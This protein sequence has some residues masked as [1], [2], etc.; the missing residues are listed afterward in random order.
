MEG[1]LGIARLLG[2]GAWTRALKLALAI[3]LAASATA[4]QAEEVTIAALGDSLTQGYG[5]PQGEG[6]VPQLEAW[7]AAQGADVEVL[8]AGV[9]GDTTAGG[10]SRVA[11]TLTP[12]VDAIIVALGGNDLLRGIDPA[13]SRANLEGI[14]TAARKAGVEVLLVGLDAPGN[15]GPDYKAAFDSMY[16]DLAEDYDA[17]YFES[18]LKGLSDLPDRGQAMRD[19][20]QEDGIHPSAKGVA[21]IVEA[22][23]PTVLELVERAR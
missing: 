10:L 2:Y 3:S 5:L 15:Y 22:M 11:W 19:Y 21:L 4:A 14:L 23:G 12:E 17:L 18:F 16:P 1:L 20:M 7:L 6:F 8:N 13:A 9:S